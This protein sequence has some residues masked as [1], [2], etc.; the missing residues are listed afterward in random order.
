MDKLTR[1]SKTKDIEAILKNGK[2]FFTK[3]LTVKFLP[4][5]LQ[6]TRLAVIVSNAV[7]KN[8]TIRNRIRRILKDQFRKEN[9]NFTVP[10]DLIIIVAK[11]ISKY[12]TPKERDLKVR[13]SLTYAIKKI[14]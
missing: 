11:S 14:R 10:L 1:L 13:E 7:H 6:V 12:P 9:P 4:N 5:N 3:D 2:A 8:S